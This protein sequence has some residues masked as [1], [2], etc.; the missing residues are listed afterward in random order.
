MHRFDGAG[1]FT[2]SIFRGC[3]LIMQQGEVM[4]ERRWYPPQH[5][6]SYLDIAVSFWRCYIHLI[7]RAYKAI[8]IYYIWGHE[9]LSRLLRIDGFCNACVTKQFSS[10]FLF[11]VAVRYFCNL[12]NSIKSHSL[13]I[14]III[15]L[16]RLIYETIHVWC[17]IMWCWR[18]RI[19]R[20]VAAP[21]K[22]WT[23]RFL[24]RLWML[25][26]YISLS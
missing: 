4:N 20:Y 17:T 15:Y 23:Q 22:L 18:G 12:L 8:H 2:W 25:S 21:Y 24:S 3:P 16:W 6:N 11:S 9:R 7:L 5:Q 13:S 14:N 1:S 10:S 26:G 19:H